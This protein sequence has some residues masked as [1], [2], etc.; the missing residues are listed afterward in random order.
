MKRIWIVCSLLI[1]LIIGC[2]SDSDQS[3]ILSIPK[4]RIS[5]P[6]EGKSQISRI[7]I[8]IEGHN[9]KLLPQEFLVKE[10]MMEVGLDFTI[11]FDAEEIRVEAYDKDNQ[12]IFDGEAEVSFTNNVPLDINLSPIMPM[13]KL[14]MISNVVSA[15]ETFGIQVLL[16]YA[17]DVFAV[18]FEIEY[19]PEF[20]QVTDVV[21]GELWN[22]KILMISDHEFESRPPGK[23]NIGI[24]QLESGKIKNSGEIA[25]VRFWAKQVGES[26]IRLIDNN[27]LRIEKANGKLIDNYE[28][29][30][31]FIDQA[32]ISVEI[33]ER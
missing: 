7:L 31:E 24:T 17:E 21:G 25:V 15:G 27:R 6:E 28:S 32:K 8:F 13:I 29:I 12:L 10:D 23:L 18:A 33:K 20:L 5:F 22:D 30:A 9:R 26:T 16:R 3:D 2:R 4:F 11:P 1:F 14:K 19:D